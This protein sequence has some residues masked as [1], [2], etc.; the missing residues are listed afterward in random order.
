MYTEWTRLLVLLHYKFTETWIMQILK[1]LL[2]LHESIQIIFIILC[3]NKYTKLLC[4]DPI[5]KKRCPRTTFKF[6]KY[7]LIKNSDKSCL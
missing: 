1:R 6:S 7:F 2:T 3:L 4:L 5:L